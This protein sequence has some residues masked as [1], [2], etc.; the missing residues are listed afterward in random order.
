MPLIAASDFE[1]LPDEPVARWL[2]LRDLIE[3]RLDNRC[4]MSNGGYETSDLLEYVVVLSAAANELEIGDLEEIPPGAIRD[5]FDVFRASVAAL[6]TRLSLRSSRPNTAQS[7]ALARPTRKKIL[8]EIEG[9]REKIS[10]SELSASEKAKAKAN[11]EKLQI[12]IISPRTDIA[13]VGCLLVAIGAFAVGS[14]SLLADLPSAIG[15]IS[16]LIGA[17]KVE[18][19]N[20]QA[21]I[22]DTS[23]RLQIQDLREIPDDELPF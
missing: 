13:R 7:V 9:L 22:E 15:T 6:A 10:L 3:S 21:L 12:L 5:N 17:D 8:L 16:A 20:E 4:D 19:E 23:R 11:L 1:S 14:T 18:E 2:Q